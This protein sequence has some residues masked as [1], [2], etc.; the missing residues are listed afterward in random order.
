VA[1]AGTVAVAF[2]AGGGRA[3]G[4]G[5]G[6]FDAPGCR[7]PA[8]DG[9]AQADHYQLNRN[10]PTP[11][12]VIVAKTARIRHGW[13]VSYDG[14]LSFD[15]IGGR[16]TGFSWDLGEGGPQSKGRRIVVTYPASGPHAI[17]LYVTD[18]SGLTGATR[19]EISVP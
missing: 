7:P 6:V 17:V 3:P 2:A 5:Q 13:R 16:L 15:P 11:T 1:V 18:D 4:N 10:C 12:P 9:P 14:S 8:Y 19:E